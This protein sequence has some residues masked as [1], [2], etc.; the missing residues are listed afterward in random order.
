MVPNIWYAEM[1]TG[2]LPQDP[3]KTPSFSSNE[4]RV[5]QP[6]SLKRNFLKSAGMFDRPWIDRLIRHT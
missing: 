2:I 1:K 5:K 4:Q 3:R 6:R